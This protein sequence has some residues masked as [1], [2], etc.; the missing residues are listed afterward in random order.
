M[1]Y[2]IICASLSITRPGLEH[3]NNIID[4]IFVPKNGYCRQTFLA[5]DSS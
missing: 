2:F 5:F 1:Y 3:I 4:D